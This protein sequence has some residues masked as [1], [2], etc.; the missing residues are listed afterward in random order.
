M[1]LNG[2]TDVEKLVDLSTKTHKEQA[3]WFLN[4]FWDDFAKN[5]ADQVWNYKHTFDEL[6]SRKDQGCALDEMQTHRF[7][8]R[9]KETLTVQQMREQLR[10]SGAISDTKVS[11]W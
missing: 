8:E 7:L 11:G 9:W 10:A 4:A 2:A 6:D 3:I 1:S 5:Q